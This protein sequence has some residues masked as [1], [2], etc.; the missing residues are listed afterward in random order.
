M[1]V[2]LRPESSL[3]TTQLIWSGHAPRGAM[4]P[5][6]QSCLEQLDRVHDKIDRVCNEFLE[7]R[8]RITELLVTCQSDVI[9]GDDSTL[10]SNVDFQAI[11]KDGPQTILPLALDEPDAVSPS[12]NPPELSI[13]AES[14]AFFG[15][16]SD[17]E[18][19]YGALGYTS[20]LAEGAP[21][22]ELPQD[23]MHSGTSGIVNYGL[24]VYEFLPQHSTYSADGKMSSESSVRRDPQPPPPIAQAGLDKVKCT[25]HG[26]SRT[27]KKNCMTRHVNEMH[28]RKVKAVCDSCG[29]RFARPHMLKVH[30]CRRKS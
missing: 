25:W 14:P 21:V 26:C 9:M 30:T 3:T 20:T 15:Q 10:D 6:L 1:D 17:L 11:I 2:Y 24:G 12:V 5:G 4:R 28:L 7:I 19:E 16:L 8:T 13:L 22:G 18:P 27:L 23:M 29:R